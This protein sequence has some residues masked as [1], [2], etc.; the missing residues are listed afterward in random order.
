MLHSC[1]DEL[2]NALEQ[3]AAKLHGGEKHLRDIHPAFSL[4]LF[5]FV[6]RNHTLFQALLGKQDVL[7]FADDF[8]FRYI[9]EPFSM[10][11]VHDKLTSI[12]IPPELITHYFAYA[13]IGTLKWW[14]SQDKPY[15]AE[16]IDKYFEKLVMPS[17]NG[18]SGG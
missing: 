8:L 9:K 18:I 7:T 16:E 11:M 1:F 14:V 5:R 13:F 10:Q 4:K 15:T 6:E 17:I 3:H 12:S 2:H